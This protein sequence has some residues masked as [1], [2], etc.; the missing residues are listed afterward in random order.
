M[1]NKDYWQKLKTPRHPIE[2]N[3]RP[4]GQRNVGQPAKTSN[5]KK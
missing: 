4:K 5:N 3:E 1:A 2:P